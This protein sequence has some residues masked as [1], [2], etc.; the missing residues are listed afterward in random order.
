MLTAYR[1]SLRLPGAARFSSTGFLA[2]LPVAMVGLGIVLLVSERTGS[3]AAAGILSASFQLPAALGA[4]VTSRWVDRLGQ[5]RLL[6]WLALLNAAFLIAFVM[7]VESGALLIV[8]ALVVAAAGLTQPAIGSMIRARWAALATRPSDLRSAFALESIIDELIFTVGPLATALI[9]FQLGLPL[10]LILAAALG[11]AGGILLAL[12]RRTE[13]PLG[14]L[15][16][17]EPS[18]T[19]ALRHPGMVLVVA[20]AMGVGAVFG[21]YEVSVVAFTQEAGSPGSSGLVLGVWAFG[22]LLAGI[23]F[24]SR[25][26]TMTLGRQMFVMPAILAVVLIPAPFTPS[27]LTLTIATVI[28]GMAVAPT[29]I[30]AFSITERLVPSRQL[31]EGLTWT[32]SGLAI[33]FSFGTA[34]AGVVVDS[35]GPSWGFALAIAGASFAALMASF[36]Q[37]AFRVAERRATPEIPVAAW[38][39][40]PL[41]GPHPWGVTDSPPIVGAT[42][43]PSPDDDVT[44]QQ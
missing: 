16:D 40:D 33:G 10:P 15:G 43:P 22:S 20:A 9:A 14:T 23:W 12:Q 11:L 18:R 39:T 27:I 2:R 3:Y 13:P 25:T 37:S 34:T 6:P 26:W 42:T 19:G 38:N 41:P 24:G 35:W 21:T 36:G 32:N 28:A 17:H 31:T 30:A 29:L 44:E 7:S 1:S 8:Q 4:V 5:H